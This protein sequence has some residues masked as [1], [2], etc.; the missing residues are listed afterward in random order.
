MYQ[1]FVKGMKGMKSYMVMLCLS[2]FKQ[3]DL[4]GQL[5]KNLTLVNVAIAVQKILFQ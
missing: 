2:F 3:A 5:L 1:F 4:N